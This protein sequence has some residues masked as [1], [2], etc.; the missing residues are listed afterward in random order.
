PV[1]STEAG[2]L[3]ANLGGLVAHFGGDEFGE[4]VLDALRRNADHL[5]D[6]PG[7]AAAAD[8]AVVL[9]VLHRLHDA[10]LVQR[11]AERLAGHLAKD[12]EH[13][14][15]LLDD[16]RLEDDLAVALHDETRG[17]VG[18]WAVR[19]VDERDPA[20]DIRRFGAA[21]ADRLGRRSERLAGFRRRARAA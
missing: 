19:N 11:D 15:A 13:A 17:V 16:R 20:P 14:G 18:G 12:G 8:T 7:D 9:D 21:P 6:H 3:D 2:G 5:A 1:R 10:D 4:S